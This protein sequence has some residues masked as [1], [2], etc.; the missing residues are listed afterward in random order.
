MNFESL[1]KFGVDQGAS[2]VHLQSGS[3]PQL[4][5]GGVMRNVEGPPLESEALREFIAGLAPD[6]TTSFSTQVGSAGRFRGAVFT[7]MGEPGVVLKT[8]PPAI[9]SLDELHMPAGVR[10]IALASRGLILVVSPAGGGKSTTLAAMTDLVNA[11]S[12]Q[13]I[14]TLEAP[15][16]YV[17]PAR[18]ALVTQMEVGLDVPSFAEGI[19]RAAALDAD[20]IVVGDLSDEASLRRALAVAESGKKVMAALTGL[21]TIQ[22]IGRLLA[23]VPQAERETVVSQLT[24]SLEGVVAQRLANTKDGKLRAAVE[25]LRGG[26]NTSRS[27]LENRLKDLSFLI[28]GRQGGM[29]SLDQHLV[30]LYQAGLISGTETMR[31]ASNP[32]VV[33]VELRTKRQ[34]AERKTSGDELI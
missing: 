34:A 11:A 2:A 26:V 29:Q 18:K 12:Y 28:E 7:R 13:K 23:L 20:T 27:I 5:I 22:T 9:P 31:L 24:G 16:E 1:L 8:I 19:T 30:E 15:V 6:G 17:L 25:V 4:R 33:A 3:S 14:V 32:E 10:Q 21:Y